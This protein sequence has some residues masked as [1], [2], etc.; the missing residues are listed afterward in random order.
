MGR[1]HAWRKPFRGALDALVLLRQSLH[2]FPYR[3]LEVWI[4]QA[5]GGMIRDEELGG[6]ESIH[7]AAH[8]SHGS[9]GSHQQLG[10]EFP[11]TTDDLGPKQRELPVEIRRALLDFERERISV[12]GWTALEHI[13]DVNGVAADGYAGNELS[14]VHG[15]EDLGEKLA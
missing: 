10:R 5:R 2:V 1:P 6:S 9:L 4:P 13:T 11:Q 14:L 12:F 3:A 15:G 7:L 8:G